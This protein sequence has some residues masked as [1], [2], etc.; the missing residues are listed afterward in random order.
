[1]NSLGSKSSYSIAKVIWSQQQLYATRP[2]GGW[3]QHVGWGGGC[4]LYRS[5][6]L[7]RPVSL[8]C[9]NFCTSLPQNFWPLPVPGE[10]LVTP[11]HQPCW[12]EESQMCFGQGVLC[13]ERRGRARAK[14]LKPKYIEWGRKQEEGEIQNS[15]E[16][17]ADKVMWCVFV[18][19]C[20]EGKHNLQGDQGAPASLNLGVPPILSAIPSFQPFYLPRHDLT[21]CIYIMYTQSQ[22]CLF[23]VRKCQ[24]KLSLPSHISGLFSLCNP[25]T[26]V[27]FH[28]GWH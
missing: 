22:C 5:V 14:L 15:R 25:P 19:V 2:P 27:L 20:V 4:S 28:H 26:H 10:G 18:R 21:Y 3:G 9:C 24:V 23:L 13:T 16:Q 6:V 7:L 8:R 17:L 12:T 11:V 1:M